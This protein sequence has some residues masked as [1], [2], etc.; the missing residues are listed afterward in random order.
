MVT[1]NTSPFWP[2]ASQ[3]RSPPFG[4]HWGVPIQVWPPSD[5]AY[6]ASLTRSMPVFQTLHAPDTHWSSVSDGSLKP[7]ATGLPS[8]WLHV[9]PP[10]LEN[11]MFT[12]LL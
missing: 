1:R 7:V 11:H 9:W 3:G 10:S 5:D 2:P 8:E 12:W 4:G 6:S